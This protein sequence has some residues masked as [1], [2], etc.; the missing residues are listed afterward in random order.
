ME[1]DTSYGRPPWQDRM[2]EDPVLKWQ[3]D[4]RT[5]IVHRGDL[6]IKSPAVVRLLARDLPSAI[7][8]DCGHDPF[9]HQGEAPGCFNEPDLPGPGLSQHPR[10]PARCVLI[11]DRHGKRT[12]A[13]TGRHRQSRD[14]RLGQEE[15]AIAYRQ[16]AI[17]HKPEPRQWY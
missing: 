10:L 6:A 5:Q 9:D 11:P 17:R 7:V 1:Q 4:A 8:P 14:V 12:T 3:H 16:A 15:L 2:K 13:L